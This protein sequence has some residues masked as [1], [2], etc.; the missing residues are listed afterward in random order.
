MVCG[1]RS[2]LA[3]SCLLRSKLSVTV[4]IPLLASLDMKEIVYNIADRPRYQDLYQPQM[5]YPRRS[6]RM[7]NKFDVFNRCNPQNYDPSAREGTR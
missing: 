5:Q 1:V 3:R 4:R 7:Q 2:D 6:K